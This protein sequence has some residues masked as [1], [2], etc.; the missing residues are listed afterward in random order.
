MHLSIACSTRR[1][2]LTLLAAA[3]LLSP[4]AAKADDSGSLTVVGTSDV[5][6]SG[7]MPNLLQPQFSNEFPQYAFKYI[8]TATGTA[9]TSAETGSQGA[10]VL[11]VHAPSLENQ[12][13]AQG[14]SFEQ[15]G[16][17]IFTND[18]ILAGPQSDPAGVSSNAAHNAAQAFADIAA[19]GINGGGSPQATFVSRGG[20][21]GTTVEEH[22]IW[23]L[24]DS[25]GLAPSGL[26]LCSLN[27]TVGGG[28]TPIT[29]G[30]GPTA[31]GQP[32]PNSGALPTGSQLPKW[33]LATGLTQGPNVIAANACTFL[34][35]PPNTCYV[36]SDRGTYDYLASG[37]DPAGTIPNL[38][39]LTRDNSALAPGG[40]N[41]LINYFHAYIINPNKPG[42]A[43]N[44]TAAKDFLDFLTNP[45]V[46]AELK[47]Y[48]PS[49]PDPGGAPFKAD[50]SPIISV[51][52]G[53]PRAVS[54]GRSVTV[55]GTLINAQ[56]GFPAPGAQKIT[57]DQ[58][59]G[60]AVL[61]VKSSTTD[62][63]GNFSITFTP[64]STGTYQ[65]STQQIAM[66][67]IPTLNPVYGDLLSPAATAG[68]RMSVQGAVTITSAR[69][70]TGK[71][72]VSGTVVPGAPDS[73]ATVVILARRQGSRGG[74]SQITVKSLKA[75]QK[76][77]AVTASLKAGKWQ[78]VARY[79]D[80]GQLLT[81]QSRPVNVTVS[82]RK[83][84]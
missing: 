6:D 42:E 17:A 55:R 51:T 29:V 47:N 28:E 58:V 41:L 9:I 35:S 33:Y 74:F 10:S 38:T 59:A 22:Q 49:T 19:A 79:Q 24:V 83:R 31:N 50:A 30:N 76:S 45:F 75:G 84:P 80:P 64:P 32:C 34:V 11:I 56:Q 43:V 7:L 77:F 73:R 46:Q 25:S 40:A 67:E 54:A 66:I 2:A 3:L 65:L 26:L 72:T 63:N 53:F 81:S 44:L 36:F 78:L 61:P 8:G 39:I 20:T 1:L 16:R 70:G 57:V 15:Y 60:G 82:K 71:V 18:F 27:A 23:Q 12:F 62:A 4:A 48:L 14:Y 68:A 21:P 69:P 52:S 5:S 37:T 13:V